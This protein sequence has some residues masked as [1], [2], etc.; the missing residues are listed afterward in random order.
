MSVFHVHE[1][2]ALDLIDA[3]VC[4]VGELIEN[5]DQIVVGSVTGRIWII[6]PGRANDT[7]QQQLLSCLLEEDLSVSIIDIAIANFVS[8][9]EKNV[10]AVLS[11]QK[12][13]IYHLVPDE[14]AYQLTKLHEH[15]ITAIAYNMCIGKFGRSLTTQICVQDMTSSLMVFAAENPLF[16][17]TIPLIP[18]IHPGP[19]VYAAYSDSIVTVSSSTGILTS[20][21]YS[22]LSA[23]LSGKKITANWTFNLGDYPL[24]LE[25][26]DTAL[27]QPSIVILCK[28]TIFCFTHGG[29]LRF[30]YRLQCVATSL[31]VYDSADD[32][33]VKLCI[34]TA[35]RLLLFFKNTISIW[36]AQLSHNAIQVRLCSFSSYRSMLVILSNSRISVS[37][38]G[39]E[40]SL[41]RIPAPQ[42]RYINFQQRYNEFMEL[43]AIIRKK[44]TDLTDGLEFFKK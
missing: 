28:R 7:K 40:P 14:E 2:L 19:I 23:A 25:T 39:T 32:A 22:V 33:Y 35:T 26:I 17:H 30:T 37:Y 43:E 34:S 10:I 24:D 29:S 18:A 5:R 9:L 16:H 31:L 41:F 1:W 12:L 6:D 36:S 38:L 21:R 8:N 4:A 27:V 11:P 44:P 3:N 42:T 15:N 20:Y 13:I